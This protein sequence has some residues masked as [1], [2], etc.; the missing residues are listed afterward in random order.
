MY[1][2]RSYYAE[3]QA[4]WELLANTDANVSKYNDKTVEPFVLYSYRLRAK[5]VGDTLS[6][7]T[8]PVYGRTPAVNPAP[9]VQPW[10]RADFGVTNAA[11]R[12]NFV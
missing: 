6:D 11:M 12:N 1:A 2:I 9:L 7:P 3:K 4:D 5:Y 10:Q 8:D